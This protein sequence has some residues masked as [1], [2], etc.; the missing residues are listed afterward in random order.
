ML[1]TTTPTTATT[2]PTSLTTT[3]RLRAIAAYL[4]FRTIPFDPQVVLSH[5]ERVGTSEDLFAVEDDFYAL[6]D[7]FA[8]RVCDD[9]FFFSRVAKRA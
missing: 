7:R 3:A 2:P 6:L 8:E 5:F 9:F 1:S 4:A